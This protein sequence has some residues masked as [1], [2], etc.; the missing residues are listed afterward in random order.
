[1]KGSYKKS[2]NISSSIQ[3]NDIME[4]EEDVP[5]FEINEVDR[6]QE[7]G[8][9]MADINKLKSGGFASVKSIL[10]AT[11]KQLQAIKGITDQKAEKLQ[12]AAMKI[13]DL[14]FITGHD[15]LMKR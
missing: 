5:E 11:K 4:E 13:E 9:N 3:K 7:C 1:M 6:L 15:L 10:M 12:E 14:G 2:K 8:I